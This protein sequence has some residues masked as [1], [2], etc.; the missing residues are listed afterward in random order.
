MSAL[1]LKSQVRFA[2][3]HPV[4]ATASLAGVTLAAMAVVV[5]HVVGAS[6]RANLEA[7][8]DASLGGY[9]HI[10]TR[11]NLAEADYF[12]LRARWRR[13]ALPTVEAVVPVIDDYVRIAGTPRRLVGLDPL[14]GLDIDATAAGGEYGGFLTDDVLF[15]DAETVAAIAASGMVA[16]LPVRVI[17]ASDNTDLPVDLLADLPTAQRLLRRENE[18]DVIWMRVASVRSWWLGILDALLPGIEAALPSYADPVVEGYHV[19]ARRHW[20][21]LARFTDASIFNL[22][23]LALLSLLMA[24][25]LVVQASYANAARRRLEQDRLLML[26]ASRLRLQVL[27]VAEGCAIGSLGAALGLAAGVAVAQALLKATD[28]A[29]P[30]MPIDAWVVGKTLFC[31]VLVAAIGP[32]FACRTVQRRRR[33][34]LAL[35]ALPLL[36]LGWAEGLLATFGILLAVCCVHVAVVVP[37]LGTAVRALAARLSR[38]PSA[39]ANWRGAAMRTSEAKLALG[40]LSVAAA[41]AIGMGLMVDSLRQDFAA[42]LEQ[43]LWQGVYLDTRGDTPP[44]FDL[45]W[46]RGLPGVREVRRYGDFNARL[47]QG[48]VAVTVAELDAA[49]AAR[50]GYPSALTQRGMLN[51]VGARRLDLQVGDSVVVHAGGVGATVRIAHVFRDFGASSPSLILPM[52]H[53]AAFDAVIR[54]RRVSVRTSAADAGRLAD[55]LGA[56]YGAEHVRDQAAVR[57]FATTVFNRSFAVSQALTVV[58]LAVA[59]IG[60]YAALTAL[61]AGREREFR[62]LCAVGLSRVE[63]WRQ[64]MVQTTILGC[65]AVFAALPLGLFIA[66]LLC[67]FVNPQAFGWSIDLQPSVRAIGLPL[68]FGIVAALLAGAIPAYRSSFRGG[69]VDAD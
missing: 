53:A 62:L 60:L 11:A 25:F 54:W 33:W 67:A 66:W 32:V 41:A 61:Q 68:L 23:I 21:P 56:R 19:T 26:G 16:E 7:A 69:A 49:E 13:G 51:E 17:E 39:R 15:A 20:N 50:Y 40:A 2:R 29:G 24:A 36:A 64:A 18:L 6:L 35:L 38:R 48:R 4:A 59:A 28:A 52:A 22:G 43:R 30:A 8:S 1:L 42:M 37:M 31:G 27:A 10:A 63:I 55:V 45:D 5:V 65:I 46:M 12:A 57:R 14:A 3:R 44:A 9:T 58:A 47:T 34:P